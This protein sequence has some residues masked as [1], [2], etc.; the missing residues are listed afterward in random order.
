MGRPARVEA[1]G[2]AHRTRWARE[3]RPHYGCCRKRRS[4]SSGVQASL[5]SWHGKGPLDR[6]NRLHGERASRRRRGGTECECVRPSD[7]ISPRDAIERSPCRQRDPGGCGAPGHQIPN[8]STREAPASDPLGKEWPLVVVAPCESE[9]REDDR[10]GN[11]IFDLAALLADLEA[12]CDI[13]TPPTRR[14][15]L[16]ASA[17]SSRQLE[18]ASQQR[19]HP[20]TAIPETGS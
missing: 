6:G 12:G 7:W 14:P 20:T 11:V 18:D 8:A 4:S 17:G 5:C 9:R 2:A 16:P 15:S 10:I 1:P 13:W 19:P 3:T